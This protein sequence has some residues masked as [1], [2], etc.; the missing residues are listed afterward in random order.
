MT[1]IRGS[2]SPSWCPPSIPSADA[3][4]PP[5][6][7]VVS[8]SPRSTVLRGIPTPCHPS[9]AA[10]LPSRWATSVRHP[11]SPPAVQVPPTAGD[12][13][14]CLGSPTRFASEDVAGPPRFLGNPH[15][16]VPCSLTPAGS[17][18]HAMQAH[19]CCLPRSRERR[20]PRSDAF[21]TRSHGPLARCLR[22]APRVAPPGRKTRFRLPG[23]LAGRGWLP[24][25][26]PREVSIR[27]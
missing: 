21:G 5:E 19:D 9:P 27:S 8:G 24:A 26:L 3:S 4:F 23:R 18:A 15:A 6:G 10:R 14:G 22:F 1:R 7:P 25:G 11:D 2:K 13:R 12:C 17:R 20:P 16:S